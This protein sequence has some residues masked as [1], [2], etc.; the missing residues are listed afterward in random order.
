[1]RDELTD[2]FGSVP[3][4]VENLIDVA[5]LRT[6]AGS[7]YVTDI[8]QKPGGIEFKVL[9]NADYDP[10]RIGPFVASYKGKVKLIPGAKPCFLYRF[11][12]GQVGT[13]TTGRRPLDISLKMC[14]DMKALVSTGD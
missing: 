5:Y 8:S 2:R 3:K 14:E 1:M 11:A 4:S 6:T 9:P 12:P 10:A 7:V 13:L